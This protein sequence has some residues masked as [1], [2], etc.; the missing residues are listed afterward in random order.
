VEF[1]A[2]ERNRPILAAAERMV[3]CGRGLFRPK[4]HLVVGPK[5]FFFFFFCIL[6]PKLFG[7]HGDHFSNTGERMAVGVLRMGQVGISKS[8]LQR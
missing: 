2:D 1:R 5:L 6:G 7:S 4:D 8:K 3:L